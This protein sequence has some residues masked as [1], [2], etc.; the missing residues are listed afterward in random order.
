PRPGGPSSAKEPFLALEL[1]QNRRIFGHPAPQE[2]GAAQL[3]T[4]GL[5]CPPL[6]AKGFDPKRIETWLDQ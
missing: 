1:G 4:T 6:E 5:C 3:P 2:P